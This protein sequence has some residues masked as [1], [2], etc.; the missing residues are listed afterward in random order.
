MLN[1]AVTLYCYA[2][3][4]QR[5]DSK[6][7]IQSDDLDIKVEADTLEDFIAAPGPLSLFGAILS[8]IRPAF[9][10][11]ITIRSDFPV[12]SGLG[13]SAT[14]AVA[15]LGCFNLTRLD[16]WDRYEL[17]EIAY[18][19]ERL[20]LGIAGGWQDQ[21][22]ASF[23]GFNFMEFAAEDNIVNALRLDDVT[24]SELEVNLLL[25]DLGTTH[26]SGAIHDDQKKTMESASVKERVKAN[27]EICYRMKNALMKGRLTN[28]GQL[29][30]E[31]WCYKKT[32]SSDISNKEIDG[33]YE[34][35]LELGAS[36]G[37]LLGAGGGGFFCFLLNLSVVH[38]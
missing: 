31:A 18:Q 9:G 5:S 22:A 26:Q 24:T 30:H 34:G 7:V 1:T 17:A 15:F 14:A 21:Y 4:H 23:G 38:L 25:C 29:L 6:V 19:A 37:K 11:E 36:G 28:F 33:I 3:M 32:F 16:R 8:L 10:F 27:V 13:G 2:S 12:G 20:S 35:A